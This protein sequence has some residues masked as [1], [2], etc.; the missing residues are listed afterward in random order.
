MMKEYAND[1]FVILA[2]WENK[3]VAAKTPEFVEE[4]KKHTVAVH[5]HV[6]ALKERA[7][8]ASPVDAPLAW[9]AA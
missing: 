1:L 4:I 5:K 2:E 6:D 7:R 8:A 9:G 3:V